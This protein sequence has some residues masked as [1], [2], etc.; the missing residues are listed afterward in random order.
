LPTEFQDKKENLHLMGEGFFLNVHA[1][2][3]DFMM[4][5]LWYY[6]PLDWTDGSGKVGKM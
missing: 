4:F 2:E 1:K 5:C 3:T 6:L